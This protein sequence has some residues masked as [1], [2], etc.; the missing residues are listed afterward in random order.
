[1][2]REAPLAGV[3]SSGT[4]QRQENAGFAAVVARSGGPGCHGKCLSQ[5]LASSGTSATAGKCG[6]CCRCGERRRTGVARE[7]PLAGGG[8]FR[9]FRNGRK[10]RVLLPLWQ[11]ADEQG[12]KDRDAAKG[13]G[14]DMSDGQKQASGPYPMM[15]PS[16]IRMIRSVC[17]AWDSLWV[18]IR[19]VLPR[20]LLTSCR[21]SMTSAPILE[22]RLPVGSSARMMEGSPTGNA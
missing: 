17:L 16:S 9:D 12:A 11:E 21:S 18:T 20:C 13:G 8:Q 10:M 1:M 2:A 5:G 6:F 14:Q 22:S 4:P 7:A 19:M 3:A 15:R